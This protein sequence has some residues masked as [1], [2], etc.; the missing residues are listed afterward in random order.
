MQPEKG[1]RYTSDSLFLYDFIT[2]FH[3]KGRVL[4]VGCGCGVVGLLIARDF[5]IKLTAID[6]Q[7]LFVKIA[8]AN[9]EL[10]GIDAEVI[11]GDFLEHAPEALFDMI[12]SNPPYY[13]AK[14]AQSPDPIIATARYNNHL[15][16]HPFLQ[17]ASS[18]LAHHG[19][20]II[21]YDPGQLPLLFEAFSQTHLRPIDMATLYPKE[22]KPAS[23]VMIR[24]KKFSRAK[25][26]IHPPLIVNGPDGATPEAK[27]VYKK[28]ATESLV[29]SE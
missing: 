4:D 10:N 7:P 1:F 6:K 5:P 11:E 19:E 12:V 22:G 23:L 8:R 26:R 25:L 14:I 3:P 13:D 21:C 2:R 24:A 29:W 9:A 18:M 27:R 16:I 20:L 28:A 15:P 17:K